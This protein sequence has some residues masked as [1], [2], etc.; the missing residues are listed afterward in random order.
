MV[1][2]WEK[3]Q[4]LSKSKDKVQEK[5]VELAGSLK[6]IDAIRNCVYAVAAVADILRTSLGPNGM[7]KLIIDRYDNYV[8]SNDGVTIL[9]DLD[10]Q[11]PMGEMLVNMGKTHVRT[12]GDGGKITVIL[13]GELVKRGLKLVE[14]G[15]HPSV[16]ISGYYCACESLVNMIDE[17][18][19]DV[20]GDRALLRSVASTSLS[21][22][23]SERAT[24]RLSD[25]AVEAVTTIAESG[26][27]MEV[28]D[29]VQF[30]KREGGGI[31]DTELVHGVIISKDI[32]NPK[33]PR[34]VEKAKIALLSEKLY[35]E[36]PADRSVELQINSPEDLEGYLE[37]ERK[38]GERK[39]SYIKRSGANVVVT[40]KGISKVIEQS[41]AK[42]NILGIRRAKPEEF[43]LLS[44]AC[45][46]KICSRVEDLREEDLGYAEVV[47][48]RRIGREKYV[49][50]SG[51]RDPKAVAVLVRGGSWFVCEEVER[52]LRN[53][54]VTV[55]VAMMHKKVV[56]GGGAI[57]IEMAK[58]VRKIAY[59]V[60]GKRQLAMLEF[61]S[62]LEMIPRILASNAGM[63][64]VSTLLELRSKHSGSLN[65][66]GID[67]ENKK[68]RDMMEYGVLEPSYAKIR[69]LKSATEFASSVLR[70]DG[71]YISKMGL[72]KRDQAK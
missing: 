65:W 8:V 18:S 67:F 6:G 36:K 28:K 57:E 69:S 29:R 7:R 59:S 61:A 26:R 49:L 34:R 58:R 37:E 20:D 13:A 50:F 11:H 10:I 15:L 2:F 46:A 66:L 25:I 21:G 55:S 16:V 45:G 23:F 5:L 31:S 17:L 12:Q 60:E 33:M 24:R 47:E 30:V 19:V 70:V 41:L 51:C 63:D 56:G 71:M 44:E 68:L 35:L 4:A 27:L 14:E 40:E 3:W 53:A 72:E 54:M 32:L 64:E 9:R 42:N 39:F 22:K 62:A 52:L 38:F 48:E 43:K 1:S